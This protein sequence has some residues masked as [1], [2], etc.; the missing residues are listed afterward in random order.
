MRYH[1]SQE[2]AVADSALGADQEPEGDE[3]KDTRQR[4]RCIQPPAVIHA[5]HDPELYDDHR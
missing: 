5:A 3:R 4:D 1:R 2:L